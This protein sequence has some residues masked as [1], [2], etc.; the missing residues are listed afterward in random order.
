MET[1]DLI[2][3]F[4]YGPGV[5]LVLSLVVLIVVRLR[6]RKMERLIATTRLRLVIGN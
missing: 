1:Q 3:M 2:N 6:D 5:T 4:L